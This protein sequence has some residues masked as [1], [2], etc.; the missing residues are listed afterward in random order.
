[1][2]VQQAIETIQTEY[3]MYTN[4][5]EKHGRQRIY[6]EFNFK[7]STR[8]AGFIGSD[9][10]E[11]QAQPCGKHTS[12]FQQKL[13]EIAKLDI[14]WSAKSKNN[15]SQIHDHHYS[16]KSERERIERGAEWMYSHDL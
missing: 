11:L 12:F 8:K 3:K 9:K 13:D 10:T 15:L 7:G 14:E 5:W 2:T 1:M 6:I 4:L 16:S